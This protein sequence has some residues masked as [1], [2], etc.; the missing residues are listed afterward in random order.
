LNPAALGVVALPIYR[1]ALPIQ[2]ALQARAFP[3]GKTTVGLQAGLPT[4]DTELAFFQLPNLFPGQ[5]A[6][7]EALSNSRLLAKLTGVDPGPFLCPPSRGERDY[8]Q[9]R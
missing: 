3:Q 8:S 6:G 1:P 2:G 9:Y 5:L 7:L 4:G